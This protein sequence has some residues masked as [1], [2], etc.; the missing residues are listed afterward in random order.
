MGKKHEGLFIK[1]CASFPLERVEIYV[2]EGMGLQEVRIIDGPCFGTRCAITMFY[3]TEGEVCC[4]SS[5]TS[6]FQGS[7]PITPDRG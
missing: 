1:T 3:N 7:T 6:T 5:S 2:C 4:S